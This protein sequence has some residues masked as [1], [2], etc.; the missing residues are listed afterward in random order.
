MKKL[1]PIIATCFF[2]SCVDKGLEKQRSNAVLASLD[3]D[4]S[5]LED[6]DDLQA[7]LF[8]DDN[9]N[10]LKVSSSSVEK[11]LQ[12]L[13]I[14]FSPSKS[15]DNLMCSCKIFGKLSDEKK[16]EYEFAITSDTGQLKTILA[17][18]VE[19]VKGNELS[20]LVFIQTFAKKMDATAAN[21]SISLKLKVS[22]EE[23][24]PI[25]FSSFSLEC[26]DNDSP[27]LI[28]ESITASA[29]EAF[30]L[31][32]KVAKNFK[33]ID[34]KLNSF[35]DSDLA[36]VAEVTF[37]ADGNGTEEFTLESLNDD[38]GVTGGGG[39]ND[40]VVVGKINED[41]ELSDVVT[42][43]SGATICKK[44]DAEKKSLVR[45]LAEKLEISDGETKVYYEY[46]PVSKERKIAI[47]F[48]GDTITI[49]KAPGETKD[50]EFATS[51]TPIELK[52][53]PESPYTYY[54]GN[55]NQEWAIDIG[56]S[57]DKPS[58]ILLFGEVSFDSFTFS[59]KPPE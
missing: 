57:D 20:G 2:L 6:F 34:C 9:G 40:V 5:K 35:V 16:S 47:K 30:S 13:E 11:E 59:E 3:Y 23:S 10:E 14:S 50:I 55:I 28:N 26:D 43:D 12:S 24:E 25:V 45:E 33:L 1:L 38:K 54:S 36:Y 15:L 17:S 19:S 29:G 44:E 46:G 39:S 48:I 42:T 18:N 31:E 49:E 27:H 41:C 7:K 21:N 4:S 32:T 52:I 8:C 37:D 22:S 56:I 51:S 58:V 53:V